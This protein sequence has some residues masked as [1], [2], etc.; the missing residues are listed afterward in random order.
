MSMSKAPYVMTF[1]AIPIFFL[2]FRMGQ[3]ITST[4]GR[5]QKKK[6]GTTSTNFF[7]VNIF[8]GQKS[9]RC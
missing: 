1:D 2:H 9:R 4:S 7:D 6:A 3:R 5:A 8:W